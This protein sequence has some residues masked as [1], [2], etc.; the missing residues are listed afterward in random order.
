MHKKYRLSKSNY[1]I[2]YAFNM[3]NQGERDIVT[4]IRYPKGGKYKIFSIL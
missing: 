3:A 4:L 1:F 2:C